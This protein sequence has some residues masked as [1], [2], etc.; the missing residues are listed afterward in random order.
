MQKSKVRLICF[1]KFRNV[2]K[3]INLIFNTNI[4][5]ILLYGF[6]TWKTTF[7]TTSKFQVFINRCLRRII[8]IS[9]YITSQKPKKLKR[10]GISS[11]T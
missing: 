5:A 10:N 6:E 9:R 1:K 8:R 4:K 7:E 3:K 2:L 11:T